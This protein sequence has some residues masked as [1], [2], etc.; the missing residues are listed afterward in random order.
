MRSTSAS[1]SVRGSARA[2]KDTRRT[3]ALDARIRAF[4]INYWCEVPVLCP[5]GDQPGVFWTLVGSRGE[6]GEV[7]KGGSL[8]IKKL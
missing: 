1:V 5:V 3:D 4:E 6:E 8:Q 7:A 2:R